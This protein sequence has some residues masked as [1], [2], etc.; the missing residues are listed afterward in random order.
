MVEE[1]LP[2]GENT[3][4]PKL[5][6]L[7]REIGPSSTSDQIKF[8]K[9]ALEWARKPNNFVNEVAAAIIYM[10]NETSRHNIEPKKKDNQINFDFSAVLR[11]RWNELSDIKSDQNFLIHN[12][13]DKIETGW[14]SSVFV[15]GIQK[16]VKPFCQNL[17]NP[18]IFWDKV[19][20]YVIN[21][22]DQ[23]YLS[24]N[25][26]S[27]EFFCSILGEIYRRGDNRTY[28]PK[29][30]EFF[31]KIDP[32]LQ[33]WENPTV[34]AQFIVKIC[35]FGFEVQ[36]RAYDIQG[37]D[38]N[39]LDES[40][41]NDDLKFDQ[42]YPNINNHSIILDASHLVPES[43]LSMVKT[44]TRIVEL[45]ENGLIGTPIIYN[46]L[47]LPRIAIIHSRGSCGAFICSR[48]LKVLFDISNR[49]K[50]Q[51]LLDQIHHLLFYDI[52]RYSPIGMLS[53]LGV[54]YSDLPNYLKLP[55]DL[56]N[57]ISELF[58]TG[59]KSNE[60]DKTILINIS[61]LSIQEFVCSTR[62]KIMAT[63][64]GKEYELGPNFGLLMQILF[65]SFEEHGSRRNRNLQFIRDF[66]GQITLR[67]RFSSIVI[68]SRLTSLGRKY[69][70]KFLRNEYTVLPRLCDMIEVK[71]QVPPIHPRENRRNSRSNSNIYIDY[72]HWWFLCLD[73]IV[74]GISIRQ[75]SGLNLS[76]G[77]CS[78]II[79]DSTDVLSRLFQR[80]LEGKYSESFLLIVAIVDYI[81]ARL[82]YMTYASAELQTILVNR[83]IS[84]PSFSFE[85]AAN[86]KIFAA[87]IVRRNLL[88]GSPKLPFPSNFWASSFG[89]PSFS[90]YYWSIS[91]FVILAIKNAIIEF[92]ISIDGIENVRIFNLLEALTEFE[93]VKANKINSGIVNSF[94]GDSGRQ[95]TI[96]IS[97]KDV[98]SNEG[99]SSD[100]SLICSRDTGNYNNN[101]DLAPVEGNKT[102]NDSEINERVNEY[103]TRFYTGKIDIKELIYELKEANSKYSTDECKLFNV[104]L[105]TLF[106]E[107][108]SFPKYPVPELRLTA[109][110]LGTLV[111]EDMLIPY[112]NAL[113]FV[114]RCIIEALKKNH[115]SKMFCFGVLA[116]EQFINKI[117]NFPQFL[118][119]IVIMSKHLEPVIGNYIR[120]CEYCLSLLP[121]NLKSKLFIEK[122]ILEN[123]GISPLMTIK[124][125][126][127]T[128][129]PEMISFCCPT[130]NITEN[131]ENC[132]V[133]KNEFG[134][135]VKL[136][137]S[138]KK[139]LPD[140]LTIEQL[141]GFGLGS[142]ERLMND[143]RI[144]NTITIP[145]DHIVEHIF[146]ICNTLA[147]TN[148]DSKAQEMAEILKKNPEFSYWFTFYLVKN[149]TSKEKNNHST[150]IGFLVKLDELLPEIVDD[151]HKRKP[152]DNS[153]V[154]I[155]RRESD[156]KVGRSITDIAA[157]ASYD[158][159]KALLCYSTLLNEVS[160]FVNIL[161]HLGFWLG[162]ITIGIN[163]PI[164]HKYLNPRQLLIESYFKGCI[165]S[166]LP[167]VCKILESAKNTHFDPPNPWT[168][169][170]LFTLAEIHSNADNANSRMFEVELLFKQLE[171]NLEDY[172]NKTNYLMVDSQMLNSYN[173][174][175]VNEEQKRIYMNLRTPQVTNTQHTSLSQ[176]RNMNHL[177]GF[178]KSVPNSFTQPNGQIDSQLASSFVPPHYNQM[179]VQ[180]PRQYQAATTDMQ[181]W[182]NKVL[183][184]PSIGLFQMQPSLR[185]LVPLALDRSIKEI[186]QV[187][188]PRSVR[189]AIITTREIV[190]KDF[191]FEP[192]E[193]IYRR[194]TQLMVSSLSGSMAIAACR[195]P[196][197]VAFIT[198][199]RQILQQTLS[200]EEDNVLVEQI[201]QLICSDNI[202]LG[203]YIIEQAVVKRAV[204]ELEDAISPGVIYRK[205]MRETGQQFVDM[206]YYGGPNSQIQTL[207][208]SSLP[209]ILKY[210]QNS[211][212]HLQLYRDFLL[213]T[214]MRNV[215]RDSSS[216]LE[217]RINNN[218]QQIVQVQ[219]Q[220]GRNDQTTNQIHKTQC[221]HQSTNRYTTRQDFSQNINT[222]KTE[223]MSS[224]LLSSNQ[225]HTN[226]VHTS[227]VQPLEPVR[228]PLLFEASIFPLMSRVDECLTQIKD[229]IREMALYPPIFPRNFSSPIGNLSYESH[230]RSQAFTFSRPLGSK[231]TLS[232]PRTTAHPVLSVLASLPSDHILFYL[233]K[234]VFAIGASASQ[235]EDILIGIS[236]K[237][238]RTLFDA[239]AAY[240]QSIMGAIPSTKC[241][242]SALGFDAALLHIEVF[243]GLSHQILLINPKFR[244]KLRSEAIGWFVHAIEEPKYSV[245][246]IVGALRYGLISSR[247]LD[248]FL[249]DLLN[250]EFH[251]DDPD[252][253]SCSLDK[254]LNLIEF[255]YKLFFRCIGDWHF[256][257]DRKLPKTTQTLNILASNTLIQNYF[258]TR[259]VII[260]G[261]YYK[262][263]PSKTNLAEIKSIVDILLKEMNSNKFINRKTG[264]IGEKIPE[265]LSFC[266][267]INSHKDKVLSP[268]YSKLPIPIT[269]SNEV[270]NVVGRIFDEWILLL[271]ITVFSGVG[272]NERNNPYRNL[273]L[274]RL[275]RQGLLKMDDRTEKL[276]TACI[277]RALY[278]SL[279]NK[280]ICLTQNKNTNGKLCDKNITQTNMDPFPLDSLV[281]LITTMARFLDPQQ[282]ISVVITHKFLSI[283]TKIIHRN[284]ELPTFNQRP[285][286]RIFF[287]FLCEYESIGQSSEMVH[288]TCLLSIVHHLHYINPNRV[289]AFAYSWVQI[290]SSNKLFPYL[291]RHAKSWQPY[292][293]LLIQLFTFISPYLK[294]IQLSCN[295]KAIYG[296][297]LRILLVLLHDF[298]EFLCDY[299]YSFCDAL[300]LNCIQIRNLIL[301]AFPRNMKLP[302]PFLPTLRIENIPEIKVV[303]RMISNYGPFILYKELKSRIDRY[304]ITR[305]YSILPLILESMKL[306]RENALKKGTKYIFPVITALLLYVGIYLP[307]GSR[308]NSNMEN[309]SEP[310][311]VNVLDI[312][313]VN[314]NTNNLENEIGLKNVIDS[315]EDPSLA[316]FLFLSRNLDMEG[317]FNFI[318]AIT[319]FLGYPNYYTFYF[320]TLLLWLFLNSHDSVVQEQITRILLERLI[321]HRP[322]P[323]GLLITFI[324]LIKNPKYS[325]WNCSFVHLAPEVEKLFQSVAQTC[326]GQ[327]ANK[328]SSVNS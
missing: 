181:F 163:Q 150:Y 265:I 4:P 140:G 175:A 204:E 225:V 94:K 294:N 298:P 89:T 71:G 15:E 156:F 67:Y 114:Q 142:L 255:T 133:S 290:I 124:N 53:S 55:N 61:I 154:P 112:G 170:I 59:L 144:Y 43:L 44:D 174:N 33:K 306:D 28:I 178:T 91:S 273:F 95:K 229:V 32:F 189:I 139:I 47:K 220:Q 258:H 126:V 138:S 74:A 158:C 165:S 262:P 66:L 315:I 305:D 272:T 224:R 42:L 54:I 162:Q 98:N 187:V 222:V 327:G 303:P 307:N 87:R 84:L 63:S 217:T 145:P 320:R 79:Q 116:M 10:L 234:V 240:Q 278:I 25:D 214:L 29:D 107:C 17:E 65:A 302:D 288:F 261:F 135:L 276:F 196:L 172:I 26:G 134:S 64:Q 100:R 199:L 242:A 127:S 328:N 111:R 152:D 326:L 203:C 235:K 86:F 226:L 11:A 243:L 80:E 259:S 221:S 40:L 58:E 267:I 197:R 102:V 123:L 245:D 213:F 19:I 69:I 230:Y 296:A 176:N 168:N 325:F 218:G 212:R 210:R 313:L 202:D 308:S 186:L 232:S 311:S 269:P 7:I 246:I 50:D 192:D 183:I 179:M 24:G 149:R 60:L 277:E 190:G 310:M 8:D 215:Y 195:E 287:A 299:S 185:P 132:L 211:M 280:F 62:S 137:I 282:M 161:R 6:S 34:Q 318:S 237:L 56:V 122:G 92:K 193:N 73:F 219:R 169:S 184:S 27:F 16:L 198:Q 319:N 251:I 194:A 297:L 263:N 78:D 247:E 244:S 85:K 108:R 292:Q 97:I 201:A 93:M 130:E 239:A 301:S 3:S 41:L 75:N 48:L 314:V 121:D 291:L 136:D 173:I 106:D 177:N 238:L 113:V 125:L 271:R 115:W 159:I 233:C 200:R 322:H 37:N 117:I 316:I 45:I 99:I 46:E 22:S 96:G 312:E 72:F 286:Y 157:L 323:W 167:F 129:N 281:K 49:V 68:L 283:L 101:I 266:T 227:M 151:F 90:Y 18:G 23:L 207:Y 5:L 120:Y 256:P 257:I 223:A 51:K 182:A 206:N 304:W 13:N 254:F 180:Q 38:I 35:K 264:W 21:N 128:C 57:K 81:R 231:V 164:V 105:Q 279:N 39:F 300:P 119:A 250:R 191:A 12:K 285:Y 31:C 284:S 188:I 260:P 205:K 131:E 1:K 36:N 295:I 236:Q 274:Q 147:S 146:T 14:N 171:L 293:S 216:Q 248:V 9:I 209:D 109:I 160:S 155:T 309:S 82:V 249:T 104:F 241:I 270:S 70:W 324:E 268:V 76:E 166:T 228:V 30:N 103:F 20:K 148:V 252:N 118:F 88:L 83:R 153:M 289:P 208:L 141:Q 253:P 275:T 321:V 143:P 77:E 2:S 110:M 52:P 317:R